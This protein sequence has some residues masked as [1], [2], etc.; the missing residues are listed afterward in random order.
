MS[1]EFFNVLSTLLF[2]DLVL[3]IGETGYARRVIGRLPL[4]WQL[5]EAQG[6]GSVLGASAFFTKK[7][8]LILENMTNTHKERK[9]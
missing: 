7:S 2:E 8:Q 1:K 6:V 5:S 3:L 9:N 4:R